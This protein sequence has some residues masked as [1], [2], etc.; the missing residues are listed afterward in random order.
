MHLTLHS[1]FRSH[2]VAS[3]NLA[4]WHRSNLIFTVPFSDKKKKWLGWIWVAMISSPALCRLLGFPLTNRDLS[5]RFSVHEPRKEQANLIW[6]WIM[7]SCI[8]ELA[9]DMM[10]GDK[11]LHTTRT[12]RSY[13]IS[14]TIWNA[15]PQSLWN[16]R[17]YFVSLYTT[18]LWTKK[19]VT[20]LI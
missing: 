4:R 14:R 18:P 6:C 13:L 2:A 9:P 11:T 19:E 3:V 1:N 8:I 20:N 16:Y 15:L 12:Y 7:G 5:I 17:A 10:Q